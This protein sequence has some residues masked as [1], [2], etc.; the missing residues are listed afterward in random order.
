MY[1]LLLGRDW[2]FVSFL[3]AALKESLN[4]GVSEITQKAQSLMPDPPSVDV[5]GGSQMCLRPRRGHASAD[6][7]LMTLLEL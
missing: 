4:N 7:L 5:G 3:F 1:I 2:H 6:R